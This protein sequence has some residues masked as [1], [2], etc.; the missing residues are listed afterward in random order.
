MNMKKVKKFLYAVL[1]EFLTPIRERR[2]YFEAHPEEVI[3]AL[4][5]GTEEARRTA[6]QTLSEVKKAMQID[7]FNQW[8]EE[9]GN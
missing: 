9:Y 7:Y 3:A 5:E 6:E 8:A 2:A 1:N 4:T